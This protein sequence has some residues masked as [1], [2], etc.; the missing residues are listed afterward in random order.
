MASIRKRNGSYLIVV[1]MGY[2]YDG[3]R[4]KLCTPLAEITSTGEIE[5]SFR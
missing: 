3:N 4:R 2:D 1:S 5:Q